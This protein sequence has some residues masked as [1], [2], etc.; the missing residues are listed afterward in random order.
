MTVYSGPAFGTAYVE[1]GICRRAVTLLSFFG[2]GWV[3]IVRLP[4]R[5]SFIRKAELKVNARPRALQQDASHSDT[6]SLLR[7]GQSDAPP[8]PAS[9]GFAYQF[10]LSAVEFIRWPRAPR[11]P[12]APPRHALPWPEA[13]GRRLVTDDR[14]LTT[15]FLP[16]ET[17]PSPRAY[18]CWEPSHPGR[19]ES[20]VS[21]RLA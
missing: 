12:T 10:R 9:A 2:Y 11:R 7:A 18:T 6:Q 14:Q 21:P 8:Q 19:Q 4:A 20:T 17:L 13:P 15:S 1:S 3:A 5:T 16:H